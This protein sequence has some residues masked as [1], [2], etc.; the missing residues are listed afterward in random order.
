M[1]NDMVWTILCLYGF[2]L[3]NPIL[4]FWSLKSDSIIMLDILPYDLRL[5]TRITTHKP[6]MSAL[7]L[8]SSSPPLNLECAPCLPSNADTTHHYDSAFT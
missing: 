5:D 1:K 2:S 6:P 4:S 8:N 3:Y 7:R